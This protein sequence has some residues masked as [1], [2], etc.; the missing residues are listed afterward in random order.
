M[1]GPFGPVDVQHGAAAPNGSP[2]VGPHGYQSIMETRAAERLSALDAAFLAVEEPAAPMHVGWVALFDP[3]DDGP[4]PAVDDVLDHI[5]GRLSRAPRYRQKLAGVPLGLHDPVWVDDDR[6]DPRAHLL[7]ADGGDLDAQVEAMLASPLPRDRPLW[8]MSVATLPDARLALLGKAHHCMVD[9]AA[10][11]ELGNLLLDAAPEG[12]RD[13]PTDPAWSPSPAPSAADRLARAMVE[14]TRDS[15][16]LVSA[17]ARLLGSPRR[18][19]ALP[20]GARRGARTLGHT[21]LPPAPGSPLNRPGTARRRHVRLTRSLDDIRTV[22]RAFRVTPNDVVLAM[23]AGALRRFAARRG[24]E[25]QRLK[26]MV[27]ADVRSSEDAAGTGNRISFVFVELPCDEPDP[28]ERLTLISRATAQRRRDGEADDLDAAFGLLARTPAP[29]QRALAQGFAHP[30]LFNLTV[31]SVAGPAVPRYLRG[32]R[33]RA[34][35]SSIPLARRHALSVGVVTVAGNACFGVT[36]DAEVLPDADGLGGDLDVAIDELLS[37]A[38]V[39]AP[40]PARG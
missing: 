29:I 20:A 30:R 2:P 34:V 1:I 21:L 40:R 31:S 23:C 14:R 17:P 19:A 18:L 4:P 6:F 36:A 7:P 28:V 22:R 35:H 12:W 39:R 15:A 25:P 24:D 11:V 3:P 10:V 9:G 5:A 8:Q 38:P 32:C 16:V 27:P 37:S 26:A 13:E 33:L